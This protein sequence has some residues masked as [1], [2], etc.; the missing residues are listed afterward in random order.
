M[1]TI[2]SE[3]VESP[4]ELVGKQL[5]F[6]VKILSALGLPRKVDRSWWVCMPGE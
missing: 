2:H 3:Y 5:G 1:I 4:E 6:K